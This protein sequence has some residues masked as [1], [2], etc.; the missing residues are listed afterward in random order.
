M[1]LTGL[2]RS[3]Q[4][5]NSD[6]SPTHIFFVVCLGNLNKKK[7]NQFHLIHLHLISARELDVCCLF[8]KTRGDQC[9]SECLLLER[10]PLEASADRSLQQRISCAPIGQPWWNSRYSKFSISSQSSLETLRLPRLKRMN[11]PLSISDKSNP[12]LRTVELC[13]ETL[14]VNMRNGA[15]PCLYPNDTLCLI[16]QHR[17]SITDMITTPACNIQCVTKAPT[18]S[19]TFVPS[20]ATVLSTCFLYDCSNIAL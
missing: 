3:H 20:S 15:A 16:C 7:K 8:Q 4:T 11:G 14:T 2:F 9:F 19:A 13:P 17:D 10:S 6:K 1:Q 5:D 12:A 18:V